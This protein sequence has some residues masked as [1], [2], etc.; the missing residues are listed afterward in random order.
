MITPLSGKR[1]LVTRAR[2]QA[3]AF[4]KLIEER[5]GLSIEIPL[6]SFEP[7]PH[8]LD[9]IELN[10]YSWIL[11][12]SA[13]GVRF[14]FEEAFLPNNVKVGAVG[15]KT[16]RALN[17]HGVQINLLPRDFVGE[18]LVAALSR[19]ALLDEKILLP[20]GNLGRKELP[21]QLMK[22]GYDVTDLPLYD[23]VIPYDSG[24]ELKKVI[25]NRAVDVITFTSSSTVHHFAHLLEAENLKD[26]IKGIAIVVIG[27]ITEKTLQSYSIKAHVVPDKYTIEGMLESLEKYFQ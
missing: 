9:T 11:F 5:G 7:R 27:P 13:N 24:S 16:A 20:R 22:L 3:A 15:S 1:V 2:E 21:R 4:T 6:I 12:T 17:D 8:I 26:Q 14:F 23:T 19:N 10:Q 25:Q 18:G